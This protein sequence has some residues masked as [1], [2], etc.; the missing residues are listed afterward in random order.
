MANPS[1]YGQ[2]GGMYYFTDQSF[3]IRANT[4][5]AASSTDTSVGD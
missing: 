3:V 1:T 2:T 4:T 5:T